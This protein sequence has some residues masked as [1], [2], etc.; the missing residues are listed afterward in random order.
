[1]LDRRAELHL[2]RRLTV[3]HPRRP[4]LTALLRPVATHQSA[5][6]QDVLSRSPLE[7]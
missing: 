3:T 6:G 5:D 2:P 1:M 7:S 4:C